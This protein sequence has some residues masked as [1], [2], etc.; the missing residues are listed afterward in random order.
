MIFNVLVNSYNREFLNEQQ[1]LDRQFHLEDL[2]HAKVSKVILKPREYF[3][4]K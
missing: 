2:D 4:T 3:L 1:E